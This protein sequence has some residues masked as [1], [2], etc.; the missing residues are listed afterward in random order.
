MSL[1]RQSISVGPTTISAQ[2][3]FSAPLFIPGGIDFTM[4]ITGTAGST[5][6]LQKSEGPQEPTD[7]DFVDVN[8]FVNYKVYADKNS[9]EGW[10]RVGVKTGN[11]STNAIVSLNR[12]NG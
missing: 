10:F 4:K 8:D 12:S 3:T 5:V 6:T 11:Y 2:N 9:T 1:N 7:G